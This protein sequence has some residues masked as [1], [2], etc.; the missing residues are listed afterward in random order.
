MHP[1]SKYIEIP[2]ER[3]MVRFLLLQIV[4]WLGNGWSSTRICAS[5]DL[6]F[7]SAVE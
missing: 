6:E 3:R 7:V 4:V 5:N 1:V 2:T